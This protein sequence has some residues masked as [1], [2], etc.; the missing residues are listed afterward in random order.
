MLISHD[1]LRALVPHGRGAEEIRDLLS[2]HVATVDRMDRLRDDLKEV[3]VGR[4][5]QAGRHPNADTLWVTKVD[6]GSGEI[7]DVVCG[8]PVVTVGTLYPFA[9]AGITLPG[10]VKLE[11]RKIRGETSN[12]MLCSARELGLGADHAG[13]MA[14]DID[15][16]PGTPFLEAVDVADV[17]FDVDVLPNRPDL[18]SHT[19]I[20]R[21]VAALTA[22]PAGLPDELQ[23]LPGLPLAKPARNEREASSGGV[24]I[25]LEDAEGCPLY[26]GVVIRGVKVG[27]SPDWLVQRL[28]SVGLRPISNVVDATNYML[29]GYGQPMHAFDLGM[30]TDRT[31]IV[32]RAVGGERMVT[33]DG[34]DR[35][36]DERMTM[37]ADARSP[38]AIG[39]VMG[40]RDSEVTEATTDLLLEV[41]CFD[42]SRIRVTRRSLGLS[43]DASYRFERGVDAA[44]IPT[45]LE[46]AAGLIMKVAGGTVDGGPIF[47]GREPTRQ[48][49]VD[50]RPARAER[51][52]GDGVHADEMARL[53]TSVGFAV[54]PGAAGHLHVTPP[55]WRRDVWRDVDLVEEI[56]RLRGYGVLS[57]V[58][59][60]FR[61]GTVPDHH[62]HVT[63]R[64]V[65]DALVGDGLAEVRP[66]P[67][68]RG[69]DDTH[70]RVA[71]PLAEDEPHLRRSLLETLARRAEYNLSRMQG[72]VRLFEIGSAFTLRPDGLPL[73]AVR[74]GALIMGRRRPPHFSEPNPP[75]YDAWDVKALGARIA[76]LAFPAETSTMEASEDG[77]SWVIVVGTGR[78]RVGRAG[79][80]SLDRPAWAAEAFGVELTLDPMPNG[81]VAPRGAHAHDVRPEPRRRHPVRYRPLPTT[82]AAE[83]DLA[84]LVRD[85]TT[86]ADVESVV[87]RSGGELLERVVLFDEYRGEGLPEGVRSLAWRL[88]FRDPVRT[89]RDKE[90]EGRRQKILRSLESELG[91]RP[92]ITS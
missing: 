66:L 26:M 53:L 46:L 58:V 29:H 59:N 55:T 23:D 27:P 51:L 67:F 70:V 52:L 3:V 56:A 1:W 8:A 4:V 43:T 42:A 39:G 25:R 48:A 36:L 40:G 38:V 7:L 73:E 41:A 57:D 61:P 85:G 45:L 10:G 11:K 92:R 31:I 49:P 24:T 47:V 89:L 64:R 54:Q 63:A 90:I 22:T 82:P 33:L 21:E 13:I 35:A 9:R 91:V 6:D 81:Y 28:E 14:L 62:L 68:V 87:R 5:V 86:A 19:G 12:G 34:V 75:A 74:V 16:A 80:V 88:T 20:A 18:L 65:R 83:F 2:A 84:L 30:L 76:E 15:V 79:P 50:L 77:R 44:A 60:P 17:R 72:D 78:R 32:R 71:N 69:G 37:I